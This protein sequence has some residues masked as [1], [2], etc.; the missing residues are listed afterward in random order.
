MLSLMYVSCYTYKELWL[1]FIKLKEKYIKNNIPMYFCSDLMNNFDIKN[2]NIN[3][4]EF[5]TKSCFSVNGNFFDRYLHYLEHINT[6]YIL[7]FYDDM[8]PLAPV[9]SE[10]LNSLILLKE[11]LSTNLNKLTN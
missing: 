6:K 4:L 10:K 8:F 5:G 1:A 3:I 7:Y 9:N 11:S 2:D